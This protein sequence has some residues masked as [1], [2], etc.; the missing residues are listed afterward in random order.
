MLAVAQPPLSGEAAD[1]RALDEGE[2]DTVRAGVRSRTQVPL[3]EAPR[4]GLWPLTVSRRDA[5]YWTEF[6]S[7]RVKSQREEEREANM[8]YGQRSRGEWQTVE[9]AA[10]TTTTSTAPPRPVFPRT[11][12]GYSRAEA[13]SAMRTGRFGDGSRLRRR[14][15]GSYVDKRG[16]LLGEDGPFWPARRGE[17]LQRLPWCEAAA[18]SGESSRAPWRDA[19]KEGRSPGERLAE[20][21]WPGCGR[22]GATGGGGRA[23]S[24]A[25]W[26][27]RQV[28]FDPDRWGTRPLVPLTSSTSSTDATS[29]TASLSAPRTGLCA[30]ALVF[31]SRFESGNLRQA[32]RVGEFEYE[33]VLRSDLHT[34][35]HTQWFYFRVQRAVPGPSYR[36]VITNLLKRDSLYSHGMRPLVYSEVAARSGAPGWCRTGHHIRYGPW[37]NPSRNPLLPAGVQFYCLDFLMEFAHVGDTCYLAHCYPYSFS[38][39][40][41]HVR[42]L[43][44][45]PRRAARLR[46]DSLCCTR[47]GNSCFLL[48]VTDFPPDSAQDD[49]TEEHAGKLGVV[50]TARVH[51]GESQASW[52]M[53]G[54]LDFLTS[55]EPS[56]QELRRKVVF[57]IV[58]MLNPDGVIVG[59]YRCSLSARDLNRNYRHPDKDEF[60]TVWHTKQMVEQFQK[61]RPVILYC[62]L[63]GH[64]RKH[65]VFMY[66]CSSRQPR[67]AGDASAALFLR[68]RLFPWLMARRAPGRFDWRSCKFR[69]RQ[70][71]ES[72][73]RAVMFRA[74]GITNAFTLEA[75]FAGSRGL[76]ARSSARGSSYDVSDFLSMGRSF[77]ECVLDYVGTRED[78]RKLAEATVTLTDALVSRATERGCYGPEGPAAPRQRERTP[79]ATEEARGS[80]PAQ[81]SDSERSETSDTESA[82]READ[83][84]DDAGGDDRTPARPHDPRRMQADTKP[85]GAPEPPAESPGRRPGE[86]DAER[87]GTR[88]SAGR[89]WGPDASGPSWAGGPDEVRTLEE[90]YRR[91]GRLELARLAAESE[92]SEDSNSDPEPEVKPE[93][94][95]RRRNRKRH[96]GPRAPGRL[97]PL[98]GRVP[99][100]PPDTTDAPAGRGQEQLPGSAR[101]V[102]VGGG[103]SGGSG[104]ICRLPSGLAPR[105]YPAFVNRYLHRTNRGIP[106]YAQERVAERAARRQEERRNFERKEERCEPTAPLLGREVLSDLRYCSLVSIWPARDTPGRRPG[107]RNS[108]SSPS[109]VPSRPQLP[110]ES[111]TGGGR[112]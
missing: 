19:V 1:G 8:S 52:I 43:L 16:A 18:V 104:A 101:P 21:T 80:P 98:G 22:H 88:G 56:A 89:G 79:R 48:T 78:P 62:D 67:G 91:L 29:S 35:R 97:P 2:E 105:S 60:P 110:R 15:D 92:S 103:D 93:P 54:A 73:G 74:M 85:A 38:E 81:A 7:R 76:S 10:T 96:R 37:S 86:G 28:V 13:L 107:P 3:P 34:E 26:R 71:K 39:L 30:P 66:G 9:D 12:G 33:L 108:L 90:C 68:E 36:F 106:M 75:S 64:S 20:A 84:I 102:V 65:N 57:K 41:A 61:D 94:A 82:R 40:Q 83:G 6:L 72:T 45:H 31:E 50:L 63:H 32:R 99:K 5:E 27:G 58:P 109:S 69:I 112:A 44:A 46:R 59:N 47:A 111:A 4:P 100:G 17:L 25:A 11:F 53:K 70:G 51:P 49:R 77:C 95:R 14:R 87:T 24:A 55:D 23:S 42:A